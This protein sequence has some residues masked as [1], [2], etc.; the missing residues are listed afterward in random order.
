MIDS[1]EKLTNESLHVDLF[2]HRLDSPLILGSGTL[3]ERYEQIEPFT[4]VGVGAV[5]PRTTRA[6]M[7]RKSQPSPCLFQT[8]SKNNEMMLNAEWTGADI[9]Y[10][11]HYLEQ[12]AAGGKVIMSVSGRDIDGCVAVCKELDSYGFPLLEINVGCSHSNSIHGWITR[13][14]EHVRRLVGSI[15]DAGVITPIGIKFS[16]SDFIV[17]MASAAKEA[18]IDCIV[19]INTFGPLLDFDI[20]KGTPQRVLGIQ[21]SMGGM[22]GSPL[23]NIALT[24][25][26]RIV[27]EV[28]IPVIGC[29]GVSNAT[30]AVKMIMAGALAV[31]IY[32]AA[33][34]RG[35]NAPSVFEEV[36]QGLRNYM[37]QHG[38]QNIAAMRGL[39]LPL[40]DYPT[41][42]EPTAPAVVGNSCVGCNSCVNVCLREAIHIVKS[43]RYKRPEIDGKACVGCGHCVSVCKSGALSY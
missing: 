25:V 6:I 40:L 29:G 7:V 27:K 22:S 15:K 12:M 16:H 5:V 13:N 11:R 35:V 3:V 8:G 41:A 43:N 19:A 23:F 33:H 39:A 37:V 26:A 2:S 32:T 21:G 4:R 36:N 24:D 42:L 28:D 20:S 34:V 10:W 30:D 14:E 38:V 31:Q 9:S 18:G 1:S 17:E